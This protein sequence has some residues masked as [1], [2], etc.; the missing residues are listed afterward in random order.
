MAH[1]P[2]YDMNNQK[3]RYKQHNSPSEMTFVR[4]LCEIYQLLRH[5]PWYKQCQG[6]QWL[7]ALQSIWLLPCFLL[8]TLDVPTNIHL[9]IPS[10]GV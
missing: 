3:R 4:L 8:G 7:R 6:N 10:F 2:I 5:R 1:V 9:D